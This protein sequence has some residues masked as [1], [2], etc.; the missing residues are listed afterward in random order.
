MTVSGAGLSAGRLLV[1]TP[2]LEEPPF[3]RTVI[4]LVEH[5]E[6][7]TLGVVLNRPLDAALD[8]AVPGWREWAAPPQVLFSGGPVEPSAML[9]LGR[10]EGGAA[11][12]RWESITDEV[13]LLDLRSGPLAMGP[14]LREARVFGGYAGWAAGQLD[15]EVAAGGWF[16]LDA[17]PDDPFS[18]EPERLWRAVL[19]RQP[20]ELWLYSSYPDDPRTN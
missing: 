17:E 12:E 1:A 9:A 13:A 8:D 14:E 4:Y 10:V 16:V 7:G 3:R 20:G 15:G 18:A 6:G 5:G 19:R 2:L 11:S